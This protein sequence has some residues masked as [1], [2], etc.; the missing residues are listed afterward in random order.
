MGKVGLIV[1]RTGYPDQR[2]ALASGVARLGRAEDNDICLPDIGVSRRHARIVVE[3]GSVVF[4][5]LGSG[6]GTWHRGKRIRSHPVNNGDELVIDPFTLRFEVE[7]RPQPLTPPPTGPVESGEHTMLLADAPGPMTDEPVGARLEVIAAPADMPPMFNIP[8]SGITMGRSEQRD[9]VV[10]DN[11]ASRLHAE[12]VK[13]GPAYWIKDPG[14]ANGLF[15]NGRRIREKEL[16]D[17]D[18]IRIGSTEFRFTR[19]LA[20]SLPPE[21][22]E[23]T[24][25]FSGVMPAAPAWDQPQALPPQ[26]AQPG[27]HQGPT[28]HQPNAAPPMPAPAP[29]QQGAWGAPAQPA[30][31]VA[32]PAPVQQSAW[33]APAQPVAQQPVAQPAQPSGWGA[34]QSQGQQSFGGANGGFGGQPLGQSMGQGQA[35]P[36]KK[37]G[38]KPINLATGG[39]FLAIVAMLAFKVVRD[40]AS[41]PRVEVASTSSVSAA[42]SA[43]LSPEEADEI[44]GL[45]SE[46]MELF[47]SERYHEA[48]R[49]FLRVLRL[50]PNHADAKRMGFVACEFIVIREL[51]E[52]VQRNAASGEQRLEA[53]EE[54]LELGRAALKG[55]GN[56]SEARTKVRTAL[57]LNPGDE[58]LQEIETKLKSRAGAVVQAQNAKKQVA[59]EEDVGKLYKRGKGELDVGNNSQAIKEFQKVLEAD[60]SRATKYYFQAEDG[61]S[62]AKENMRKAADKPYKEGVSKMNS[63]DYKGARSKFQEAMRLDPYHAGAKAKLNEVKGTLESQASEKFKEGKVWESA[64]QT[65]KALSS[66]TQCQ[67]LLDDPSHN[68][69]KK[70][71]ARIDALL[72]M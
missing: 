71:Q 14:A 39:I 15:V 27:Y 50:D 58:E 23:K 6:N 24:E 59:L 38:I 13:V 32:Q 33:G 57:N 19:L 31:P 63:G 68:L 61:I 43:D 48:S 26:A 70:A 65:D 10:P 69:H 11:A 60:P 47:R 56:L 28:N 1:I 67:K 40:Q 41:N 34:P 7:G 21:P 52:S 37:K 36:V 9:V 49:K 54:A 5:D 16:E 55:K 3:N 22:A 42:P 30:Q 53:K 66:Y 45:M 18:I 2:L 64:N 51:S 44:Y 46:G 29:I 17:G 8:T 20:N 25:N 12:I 35:A 4:E 62:R 72:A